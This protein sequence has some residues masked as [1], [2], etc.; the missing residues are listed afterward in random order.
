MAKRVTDLTELDSLAA[1]DLLVL[2]DTSDT[3][4]SAVGTSKKMK[5]EDII[6]TEKIS[7]SSAQLNALYTT[8]VQLIAAPGSGFTLIPVS[9]MLTFNYV[10]TTQSGKLKF[11]VGYGTV[12]AN[13]HISEGAS[14]MHTI[15]S[16]TTYFMPIGDT[17]KPA[18]V[19]GTSDNQPIKCT[20]SGNYSNDMTLDVYL[21]Y[22][23][24][25]L[26]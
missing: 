9:I 6:Y 21:T 19:G 5:A 25:K 8:P 15:T 2:V 14:Y 26:Y 11:Y 20:S 18:V 12:T 4:S 13:E 22:K 17:D 10:S 24:Y 3:S 1:N 23:R 7:L 16:T